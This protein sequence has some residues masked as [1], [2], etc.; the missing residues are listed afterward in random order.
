MSKLDPNKLTIVVGLVL[1]VFIAAMS[2][3]RFEIS[4]DGLKFEKR[5]YADRSFN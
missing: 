1:I 3:Y 2:G 4:A 5:D